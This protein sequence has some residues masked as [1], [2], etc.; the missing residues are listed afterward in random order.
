MLGSKRKNNWK[1]FSAPFRNPMTS[2][3]VPSPIAKQAHYI[4]SLLHSFPYS[5]VSHNHIVEPGHF[6]FWFRQE[7]YPTQTGNHACVSAKKILRWQILANIQRHTDP[8]MR[9]ISTITNHL[10]RKWFHIQLKHLSNKP[11]PSFNTE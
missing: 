10:V 4:I 9:N 2:V 5:F 1:D 11:F 3:V 7:A 8:R 6:F